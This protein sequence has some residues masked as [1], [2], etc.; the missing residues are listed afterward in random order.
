MQVTTQVTMQMYRQISGQLSTNE[1]NFL[2][3]GLR[4][5]IARS[6]IVVHAHASHLPAGFEAID[7][8]ILDWIAAETRHLKRGLRLM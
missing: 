4:G 6:P 7:I 5:A 1:R 8:A 2:L 3:E